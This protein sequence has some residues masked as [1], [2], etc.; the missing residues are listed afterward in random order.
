MKGLEIADA[1]GAVRVMLEIK[2]CL[3]LQKVLVLRVSE[4]C[5]IFAD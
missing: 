3:T 5:H 1:S 2:I 4:N